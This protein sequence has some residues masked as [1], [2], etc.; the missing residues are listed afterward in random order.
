MKIKQITTLLVL[1]LTL[2]LTACVE[3]VSDENETEFG[4][5][6][7]SLANGNADNII[8]D[9]IN[10]RESSP[11][12]V[13]FES[14]YTVVGSE[15]TLY[16]GVYKLSNKMT[17]APECWAKTLQTMLNK[18]WPV[19][20][21]KSEAGGETIY[22]IS[23]EFEGVNQKKTYASVKVKYNDFDKT[24]W[25]YLAIPDWMINAADDPKTVDRFIVIRKPQNHLYLPQSLLRK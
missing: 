25:I 2:F 21:D 16:A 3:S 15:G 19:S 4:T 22:D 12:E 14:G 10:F 23:E 17:L 6:S 8:R 18:S 24:F 9:T 13:S 20:K 1:S 7:P 11:N 5:F